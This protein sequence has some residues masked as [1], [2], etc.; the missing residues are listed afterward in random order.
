[1]IIIH[2][3]KSILETEKT[4][5]T[6]SSGQ[7]YKKNPRNPKKTHWAGFFF[8]LKKSRVFS[9][10]EQDQ[11]GTEEESA[12]RLAIT[13][14]WLNT[15]CNHALYALTDVF[16]QYFA[17]VSPL[18][19][20]DLFAQLQWCV[21]QDNEQLARSGISCLENLVLANGGKFNAESWDCLC[22]CVHDVFSST[23]PTQLLTWTPPG[24]GGGRVAAPAM[25]QRPPSVDPTL[26]AE[27]DGDI[28][29]RPKCSVFCRLYPPPP[30]Q[31]PWRCLA[32][33]ISLLY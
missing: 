2:A 29:E 18:L 26:L 16:S 12:E 1:V 33:S 8:C 11:R 3:P 17:V 10:P 32:S 30:P 25:S 19:L 27:I 23:T 7:I 22:Q 20:H 21:Q 28:G 9:N 6:L 5:K 24:S 15:T 13:S 31:P 4:L 14:E